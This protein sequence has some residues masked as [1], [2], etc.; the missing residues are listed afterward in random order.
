MASVSPQKVKYLGHIVTPR[1][2]KDL[3][4]KSRATF[5]KQLKTYLRMAEFYRIW[6]PSFRVTKS[7]YE[8]T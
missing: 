6:V 1:E 5:K 3:L 2:K 4:N 7:L 8:S